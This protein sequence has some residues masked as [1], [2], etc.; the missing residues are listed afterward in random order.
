MT[1]EQ[2]V[3]A[4]EE[5]LGSLVTKADLAE[6]AV[7]MNQQFS[8]LEGKVDKLEGKV[9]ANHKSLKEDISRLLKWVDRNPSSANY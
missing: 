1:L 7:L 9:D 4:I 3:E 8:R 6:L 5:R 2:Q